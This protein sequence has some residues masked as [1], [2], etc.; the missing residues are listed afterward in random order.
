MEKNQFTKDEQKR[1][2]QA[3]KS[4]EEMTSGEVQVQWDN[5]CCSE[6]RDRAAD[7]FAILK[8]HKTELRN[9]VLF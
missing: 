9:G 6:V 7:V 2:V 4:S 1:I 8:M 5:H 3:I